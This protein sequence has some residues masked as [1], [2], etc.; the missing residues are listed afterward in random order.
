MED[1]SRVNIS[2]RDTVLGAIKDVER[3]HGQDISIDD[4]EVIA[5]HMMVHTMIIAHCERIR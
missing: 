1:E 4:A 2:L 3:S 5:Y